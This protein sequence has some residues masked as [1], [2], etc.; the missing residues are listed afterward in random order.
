MIEHRSP[1]SGVASHGGRFVATA[2]YDNQLIL[3]DA[4]RKAP[5]ARSFHDHLAN[6]VSFSSCGRWLVSASSDHTA[7]VWSLP[8]LKLKAVLGQHDDDVE[9][10]AFDPAGTRVATASRD[11]RLH[12]YGIDG[13]LHGRFEGH[14]ADVISV[15]WSPCGR[16][17][18]SSSDDGT[19]KRWSV[20]EQRLIEDID[21]GG[22]ETD[23]IAIGR[24]GVVYAGNDDGEILVIDGARRTGHP[25][26][27]AGIKRLVYEADSGRLV[28]LSYD[29]CLRVWATGDALRPLA[30]STMPAEIW[31][32]SCAFVDATTLAFATFGSSYAIYRIDRDEWDLAGVRPTPGVNAVAVLE[33]GRRL[34]IGDAGIVSIDGGASTALGS[35]CNFLTPCGSRVFTG[36]QMGRVMDAL[37][38][39]LLH[40]HRSPLNCGV[41]FLKNGVP[42]VVVG[43]YT[44]EGLVFSVAADGAVRLE[45]TLPLHANAV[46]AVAVSG[47]TLF[48]VCADRAAAWFSLAD[49]SELGRAEAAHGRIANG[50]AALPGGRFVSVSRDLK[51]RLWN[52]DRSV[53]A[54]ATPHTH[55]IK[56]VAASDD[57]RFVASGSYSG[58]VALL[59]VDRLEWVAVVRPTTAGISSLIHDGAS[60][61]FLAGSYDSQVYE[62]PTGAP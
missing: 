28:S 58:V 37:S 49:F 34:T 21:L 26:H 57:G 29:R 1:I 47:E 42:H 3:W 38:G 15:A 12:V 24:D 61:C 59:D 52:A 33:D 41:R 36:G 56:C 43:T 10:A 18:I 44:G 13:A 11:H 39:E 20:A 6:Q 27:D 40:Q 23:T 51:L 54:L 53:Q 14:T 32:R 4:Q 2:G 17:L 25:A 48:A 62:I 8:G 9:M 7:R 19:V 30:R 60:A 35:L 50:C 5:L 31:P 45:A 22:V 16:E 55:S 46:K